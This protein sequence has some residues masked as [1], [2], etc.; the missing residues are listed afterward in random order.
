[1]EGNDTTLLM[2]SP[3]D[4]EIDNGVALLQHLTGAKREI[5]FYSYKM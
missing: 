5:A 4:R 2:A 3:S 1:M